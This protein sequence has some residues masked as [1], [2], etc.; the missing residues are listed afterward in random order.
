MQET[1]SG[2]SRASKLLALR[3][4][5]RTIYD[6]AWRAL[7][8]VTDETT[9]DLCSKRS[10]ENL[11]ALANCKDLTLWA[12]KLTVTSRYTEHLLPEVGHVESGRVATLNE[13]FETGLVNRIESVIKDDLSWYPDLWL[14]S[15]EYHSSTAHALQESVKSSQLWQLLLSCLEALP[16][17]VNIHYRVRRVAG[18]C[19]EVFREMSMTK[20]FDIFWFAYEHSGIQIGQNL[21]LSALAQSIVLPKRLE[22]VAKMNGLHCFT[23]QATIH[24]IKKVSREVEV[25]ILR[26]EFG[27]DGFQPD[28]PQALSTVAITRDTFPAL[29]K[30]VLDGLVH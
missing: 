5:S 23:I 7:A 20:D 12:R 21:L 3:Y 2:Q 11:V 9:F 18:R 22:L 10:M 28:R 14:S 16:N 8:K 25:L 6:H 24:V 27:E 13:A 4:V 29:R 1:L 30:L 15:E 17:M 26:D 19:E